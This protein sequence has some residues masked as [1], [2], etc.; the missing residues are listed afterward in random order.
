MPS[1][2]YTNTNVHDAEEQTNMR[3]K[4]KS[5]KRF[6]RMYYPSNIK[7]GI[8]VN[9]ITG[10]QYK[11]KNNTIDSLRLFRVIDSTGRCDKDGFYDTMGNHGDTFNK[12]PNVLFYDGPN[13]YMTHRNAT[14]DP[15][16][17]STWNDSRQKLFSNGE[18]NNSALYSLT[19][20]GIV[21][22]TKK[23]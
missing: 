8:I 22:A 21:K 6:K 19:K 15:S 20:S 16:M 9:A 13:E 4:T 1:S 18:L 14:L 12:E 7:A 23:M 2:T 3:L 5:S 11:W 17:V 10:E